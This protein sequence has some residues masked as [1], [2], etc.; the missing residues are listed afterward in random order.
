[1]QDFEHPAQ[2][3]DKF[4]FNVKKQKIWAFS[5]DLATKKVEHLVTTT[6]SPRK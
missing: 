4:N 3:N 6:R 1:M 5:A 2:K